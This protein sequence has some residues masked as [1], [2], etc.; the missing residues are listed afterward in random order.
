[1]NYVVAVSGG[2]D[3]VV[4]LDILATKSPKANCKL[5]V[6]H[7]DHGIRPDSAADARFVEALAGHYGLPYVTCRLELG[8]EASED[9]ARQARYR[10]L[11]DQ[12]KKHKAIVVTAH[13]EDDL[14]GSVAINLIRGTGW[15][16]LNV[17]SRAQLSRPLLG[18][19]KRQIYNYAL[20]S[21]LEWVEDESNT[22]S[23][24]LRNQ[25]RAKVINLPAETRKKL[26]QLRYS[27]KQLA[28]EIDTSSAAIIEQVGGSRYFY[29]MID[30]QVGIE[31]LRSDL[32]KRS[33]VRPT[34]ITAQRAL[35]AIKTA[36]HA[37]VHEISGRLRLRFDKRHFIV[38]DY[39]EVVE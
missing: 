19:T 20:R 23:R 1:M 12:A 39:S 25:L 34:Y 24:Y 31:L 30:E 17:M 14:I 2:V 22:S 4:L 32:A 38:E 9:Q 6:A 15:R 26:R 7:V 35:T 5:I 27:Q 28:H 37:A 33:S 29:T 36:R 11:I 13:H 8:T 21:K 10:F 3:S 16:G 18:W